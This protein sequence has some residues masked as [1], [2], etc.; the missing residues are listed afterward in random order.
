MDILSPN[1]HATNIDFVQAKTVGSRH[2]KM[3]G[4]GFPWFASYVRHELEM[5]LVQSSFLGSEYIEAPGGKFDCK[6]RASTHPKLVRK[7]TMDHTTCR[8]SYPNGC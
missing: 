8:T 6:P 3:I 4:L 2:R 1:A 5:K 7:T